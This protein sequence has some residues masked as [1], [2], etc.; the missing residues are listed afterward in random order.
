MSLIAKPT[1]TES[2]SEFGT[3]MESARRVWWII[4]RRDR[5]ALL[6]AVSCMA[7][8]AWFNARIPVVLGDLGTTM[9]YARSQGMEWGLAEAIAALV[10]LAVAF[11]VREALHVVRKYLIH[12][13]TT[14]VEKKVGVDVVAHI[15]KVDLGAMSQERVG[16]VNGRIRRSVE[17]LVKLL[18]LSF[19]DF[20]PALLTAAFALGVAMARHPMLGLLMAGVIPIATLIVIMQIRSQKGI[21]LELLRSK[22]TVDGTVVEQLGGIEYVRAADTHNDEVERVEAAGE[23]VRRREIRHHIAM[24]LFDAAKAINEGL[25]FILVVGL[26]IHLA[27][28]RQISVGDILTF[29]LLF[30]NVLMPLRDVHRI[31]DEAHESTLKVG[32]LLAMLAE[33]ADASFT[34]DSPREPMLVPGKPVIEAIDLRLEYTTHDGHARVG[35]QGVSVNIHH[36]ETVGVAGPSGAG[37]SSWLRAL[38]RLAHPCGGTLLLGGVPIESVPREAIGR[39]FGYVG[40]TPFLFAGTIRENIAYGCGD[41]SD[42]AVVLAAHRAGIHSEIVA[43]AGGYGALVAERGLNL[44]GGQRQ[45]IALARVFLKNPPILI[46]DEATSALDTISERAVQHAIVDART[47]RTVILVAH[48]LSTVR[49]AD[50]ILVFDQGQIVESGSYDFLLHSEGIFA[51]LVRQAEEGTRRQSCL[52]RH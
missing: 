46:L 39:L 23:T 15:M 5:W 21:R 33:P 40:Q 8:A 48:R 26:S 32:D 27:A 1:A 42:E 44:S 19:M 47:D 50:R 49:D 24:S 12:D 51:E 29:A 37:K 17:G 2:R 43:M 36:G 14:R 38:L 45:R 41:V 35:M 22:E 18:K 52:P 25:F 13:T 10:A 20:A 16:A 28:E 9:E 34:V 4:G 31:L 11:L 6:A 7:L 3:I 30:G